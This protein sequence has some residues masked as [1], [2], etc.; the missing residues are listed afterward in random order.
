MTMIEEFDFRPL[1]EFPL[2]WRWTDAQWD[3]LPDDVLQDIKPL[4]ESKALEIARQAY[5][6]YDR[7]ESDEGAMSIGSSGDVT[8]VRQWLLD[9]WPDLKEQVVVSWDNQLAVCVSWK[10]FCLYWDDFCYPSSDDVVV[11]PLTKNWFLTFNH[12]EK[13]FFGQREI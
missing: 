6:I 4:S 5:T 3:K 13:F 12:E 1:A 10:T 7:G 2:K 9:R 8:T 11:Q